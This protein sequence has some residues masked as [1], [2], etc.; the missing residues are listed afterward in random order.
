MTRTHII[1][2]ISSIALS[3][4]VLEL[5]RRRRLRE[6]YSWLWLLTSFIYI[7]IAAWPDLA[8][9]VTKTLGVSSASLAFTFLGLQF[10][11]LISIQFSTR[12]SRLATQTK[13]LAQQ[14]AILDS[15]LTRLSEIHARESTQTMPERLRQLKEQIAAI[16]RRI[17]T[18]GGQP[19]NLQDQVRHVKEQIAM[20]QRQIESLER[21]PAGFGAEGDSEQQRPH[22][23]QDAQ[24]SL[25]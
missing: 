16:H 2:L 10:L 20:A 23:Q 17:E 11:V 12:L 19:A 15:E 7:A 25:D 22:G 24:W 5:V 13:D 3:F 9:W 21:Q 6:E 1:L 4:F 14:I 18:L 8:A